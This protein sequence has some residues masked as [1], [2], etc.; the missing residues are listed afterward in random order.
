MA[1]LGSSGGQQLGGG[2][3]NSVVRDA[4]TVRKAYL[5]TKAAAR[6]TVELRSLTDM[7]GHLPVQWCSQAPACA[8]WRSDSSTDRTASA[9]SAT[10]RRASLC[11]FAP[12][13]G[14]R[15]VIAHGDFGPR[16]VLIRPAQH[17]VSA[18]I[19]WEFLHLGHHPSRGP[20]MGGMDRQASPPTRPRVNAWTL[21]RL[22]ARTRMGDRMQS[23]PAAF[24]SCG[25]SLSRTPASGTSRG[26][27][28]T[29][30]VR[31]RGA[32]RNF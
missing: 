29:L 28:N 27:A 25:R 11:G 8:R 1:E 26:G 20:C 19:D 2:Y 15:D 7:A 13:S 9:W 6:R 21:R 4:G 10:G 12:L 32:E 17:D 14:A 30:P 24:A 18:V 22:G 5:G 16:N 3:L 31:P 23:M